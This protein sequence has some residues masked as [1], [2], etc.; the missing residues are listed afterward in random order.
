MW[1]KHKQSPWSSLRENQ[2]K[3]FRNSGIQRK[4]PCLLPL[5]LVLVLV[6]VLVLLS[7]GNSW[8]TT[9]AHISWTAMQYQL[10]YGSLFGV[11]WLF[12]GYRHYSLSSWVQI[13]RE[14]TGNLLEVVSLLFVIVLIHT[15]PSGTSSS[16][17]T[18]AAGSKK[19]CDHFYL[20]HCCRWS[21]NLWRHN[22]MP[23]IIHPWGYYKDKDLSTPLKRVQK[24]IM[25][26]TQL[27]S[28]H[29]I[30]KRFPL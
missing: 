15:H 17:D 8:S 24:N 3:S 28:S 29:F 20:F 23:H 18:Q 13:W 12:P 6:L 25:M 30:S 16:R 9:W 26:E 22:K 1:K 5:L 27:S 11:P 10:L 4:Q 21:N 2:Q 7:E 19:V 14:H